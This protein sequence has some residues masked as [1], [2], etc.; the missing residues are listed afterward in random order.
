LHAPLLLAQSITQV[1]WATLHDVH[2]GGHTAASAC[3]PTT[4]ESAAITQNPSTQVRPL[5]QRCSA[6]HAKSPLRWLSEQPAASARARAVARAAIRPIG[7]G[8]RFTAS[9]RP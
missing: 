3:G 6:S 2:A 4:P 8:A 7:P 1:L 5:A 9:L